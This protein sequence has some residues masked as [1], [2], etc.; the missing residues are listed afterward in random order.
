MSESEEIYDKADDT[1][2]LMRLSPKS[3][4]RLA[5]T[6]PSFP[7]TRIGGSLRFPR[8]RVLR[9]LAQRTQGK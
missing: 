3:V 4:Y 1:G 8:K 5:K 9:W 7:V 6:D 2:K